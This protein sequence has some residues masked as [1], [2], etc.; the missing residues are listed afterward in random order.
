MGKRGELAEA[1]FKQGYNCAQAVALAFQ[2]LLPLDEPT[3]AAA[4][5]PFGGGVAGMRDVCGAISGGAMVIGLL[6]PVTDPKDR[7][8]KH[9]MY[10]LVQEMAH[11]FQDIHGSIVCG[12]L[13][14]LRPQCGDGEAPVRKAPCSVKV[15]ETADILNTVLENEGIDTSL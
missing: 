2:D 15:R 11:R 12:E 13:L 10:D 3:T 9:E 1:L 5:A 8:G 4:T 7:S 6:N 14:G